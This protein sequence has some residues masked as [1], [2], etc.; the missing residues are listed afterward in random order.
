M[1]I[2][3]DNSESYDVYNFTCKATELIKFASVAR[4]TPV[5]EELSS[6]Q[7]LISSK[8]ISDIERNLLLSKAIFSHNIVIKLEKDKISFSKSTLSDESFKGF[9]SE[10]GILEITE[11]YNTAWIIDGQHRLFSFFKAD[12][13]E[14]INDLVNVAAIVGSASSKRSRILY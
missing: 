12:T 3:H 2:N 11:D 14:D 1:N 8:R 7:R 9:D 10:I 4:R 5:K 13:N 6:Y